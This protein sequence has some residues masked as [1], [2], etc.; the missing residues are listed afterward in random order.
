MSE[1]LSLLAFDRGAGD[2]PASSRRVQTAYLLRLNLVLGTAGAFGVGVVSWA[3]LPHL[4]PE[5]SD[6]VLLIWLLLPGIVIQGHARIALSS[7]M[8]TMPKRT[9]GLLGGGSALL[10]VL[11]VPMVAAYGI[12]GAAIG[13]TVLYGIQAAAVS[14]V[15]RRSGFRDLA[16]ESS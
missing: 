12:V 7:V 8:T 13:S 2:E 1:T 10:S 6:A 3:A 11:Y 4:L 14:I 9:L 15:V 5:F 16:G